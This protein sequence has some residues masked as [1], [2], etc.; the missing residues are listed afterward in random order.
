MP[1]YSTAGFPP[2][3]LW[4]YANKLYSDNTVSESC[5]AL[6]NRLGIDVN[7]LLFCLWV[8]ASGRQ[9]LTK[10]EL[11]IGIESSSEWQSNVV[12]PL[13]GLRQYLKSPEKNID[14][15][16]AGDLRRVV[17]DSE[18]YTER[19]EL[20]MLGNLINRPATSSFG[21]QEC[22]GAGAENLMAYMAR[23]VYVLSEED[24]SDLLNIWQIAFP[25]ANHQYCALI[26]EQ[27]EMTL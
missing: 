19:L 8:A 26:G 2:C 11:E 10:E 22:A 16:L 20:Q 6:Q 12:K 24:R 15:R 27:A 5:L 23:G 21:V 14:I 1:V 7:L 17:A 4:D 25:A 3:D 9:T 13:R 18:I